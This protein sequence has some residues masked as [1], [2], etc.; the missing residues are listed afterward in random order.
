MDTHMN[1]DVG[2]IVDTCTHT[3]HRVVLGLGLE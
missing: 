3:G 2:L 1:M